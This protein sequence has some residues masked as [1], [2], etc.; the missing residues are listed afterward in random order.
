MIPKKQPYT[1]ARYKNSNRKQLRKV[2]M[3][4]KMDITFSEFVKAVHEAT[5]LE[6]EQSKDETVNE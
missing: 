2:W 5:R 6:E 1:L 3:N 4:L